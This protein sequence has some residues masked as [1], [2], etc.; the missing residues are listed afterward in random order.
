MLELPWSINEGQVEALAAPQS[1]PHPT[2]LDGKPEAALHA[3]TTVT[4]EWSHLQRQCAGRWSPLYAPPVHLHGP[5]KGVAC[6]FSVRSLPEVCLLLTVPACLPATLMPR[7]R[8]RD[9][10]L[11]HCH[12]MYMGCGGEMRPEVTDKYSCK[13]I[14]HAC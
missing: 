5:C 8:A 7:C 12:W 6:G 2:L 4:M 9:D 3:P 14:I 10:C 11:L 13:Q 1:T